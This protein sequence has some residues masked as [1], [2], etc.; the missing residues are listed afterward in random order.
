MEADCI[1]CKIL[2]GE[3][4]T[5]FVFENDLLVVFEDIHPQAPVHLLIVPRKHIRSVNEFTD[6][7][8]GIVAEIFMVAREMA[9][10]FGIRDSGYKLLFNVEQGGGQE[11]FHLHLH[12]IGG[13]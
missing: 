4:S 1:F 6:A 8:R 12:L 3:I 2:N 11:I 13:W 10:K 7:D 9:G 5:P